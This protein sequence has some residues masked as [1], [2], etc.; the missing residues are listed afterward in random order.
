[1]GDRV[2]TA[3]SIAERASYRGNGKHK[4]YSA[5]DQSWTPN[6]RPGV[7]ECPHIIQ[8][9]WPRIEQL[10]RD[11]IRRSCVQLEE[12]REFPTRAWAFINDQ[13]YEARITN[14]STGEYHGFPLDYKSQWPSDPH[15][16]LRNAPR[17]Q[18]TVH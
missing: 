18:V 17:V 4:R 13:L 1:L 14:P 5:S 16:L 6:L 8:S 10:L 9:D 7:S 11:A 3:Q 15:D 2:P 12:N